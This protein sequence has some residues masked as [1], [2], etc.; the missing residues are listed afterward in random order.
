MSFSS[1]TKRP[2]RP[3]PDEPSFDNT[4]YD[5]VFLE[6]GICMTDFKRMTLS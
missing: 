3:P 6:E 5:A 4:D 1:S 2:A